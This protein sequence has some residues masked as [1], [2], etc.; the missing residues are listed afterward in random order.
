MSRHSK[1]SRSLRWPVLALLAAGA[2]GAFGMLVFKP[3]KPASSL[4]PLPESA[5]DIEFLVEMPQTPTPPPLPEPIEIP[6]PE[7]EPEPPTEEPE[8]QPPEEEAPPP[9]TEQIERP[10]EP[11]PK[12]EPKPKPKVE[13]K[14]KTRPKAEPRPA[15]KPAPRN[16]SAKAGI[17][18]K[19][20]PAYPRAAL[21]TKT[22]GDVYVNVTISA[23]GRV[24]STNI[25]KGSGNRDLDRAALS[26]VRR[27]RF[28]PAKNSGGA[29]TSHVIVPV[30]FRVQ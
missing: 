21:R 1:S 6:P 10:L 26:S 11:K 9:E 7:P 16:L 30:R 3:F 2:H 23:T 8:P 17:L 29:I 22:E 5:V 15:A 12:V 20:K 18:H 27:W 28:S 24:A 13:T 25:A 4:D 14:P 19:S